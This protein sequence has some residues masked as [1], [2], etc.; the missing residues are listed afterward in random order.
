[1]EKMERSVSHPD[2]FRL[3]RHLKDVEDLRDS[4]DCGIESGQEGRAEEIAQRIISD[5]N[6]K[7]ARIIILFTSKKRRA[8]ESTNLI[9]ES[10]RKAKPGIRVIIS[11]NPN[12]IDLDQ[13][14][15]ILPEDYKVGDNYEPLRVAWD[16]FLTETFDHD[17]PD[18]QF[19]DPIINRDG[20]TT[21]PALNGY[22]TRYGESRSNISLRLY[23][24]IVEGYKI[25]DRIF[26]NNILNIVLTHSLPYALIKNLAEVARKMKEENFTLAKGTLYKV[27]WDIYKEDKSGQYESEYGDFSEIKI[28]QMEDEKFITML[29]DEIKYLE[30]KS[31]ETLDSENKYGQSA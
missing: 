20:I 10:L 3:F 27:C 29:Q 8:T 1:M 7:N 18:Y 26:S 15:Y 31:G 23:K 21:Y 24:A 12:L 19:G 17:N 30:N 13:G 16:A 28:D 14:E 5:A 11:P 4:R 22:F 6:E 9:A 2:R 25:K